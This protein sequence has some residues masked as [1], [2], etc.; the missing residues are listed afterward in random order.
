M[1]Q[2]FLSVILF[3]VAVSASAQLRVYSTDE[4]TGLSRIQARI[5]E[6]KMINTDQLQKNNGQLYNKINSISPRYW[7]SWGIIIIF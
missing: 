3:F 4:A 2:R 7:N 1:K 6:Q 5:I